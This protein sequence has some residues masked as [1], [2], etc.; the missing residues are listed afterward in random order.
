MDDDDLMDLSEK[1]QAQ[2]ENAQTLEIMM[3]IIS[4]LGDGNYL[5]MDAFME[6][7]V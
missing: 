1:I 5:G 7:V 4:E 3:E 2:D 6:M